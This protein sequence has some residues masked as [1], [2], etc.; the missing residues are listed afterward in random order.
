MIVVVNALLSTCDCN[1]RFSDP[2]DSILDVR[3]GAMSNDT[4]REKLIATVGTHTDGRFTNRPMWVPTLTQEVNYWYKKPSIRPLNCSNSRGE[5]SVVL[6]SFF[7]TIHDKPIRGSFTFMEIGAYDGMKESNTFFFEKCL[8]WTGVLAEAH[9]RTFQRLLKSPRT[10][11]KRHV[12]VCETP[13]LVT[14]SR[15]DGTPAH[16]VTADTR[17]GKL[18]DCLPMSRIV[19]SYNR[20]DFLSLDVEGHEPQAIRSLGTQT[21]FGDCGGGNGW[22]AAK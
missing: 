20:I 16:I 11:E 21:S 3:Y 22:C 6:R 15:H 5:D 8:N 10:V 14:I 1:V 18:V 2:T 7:S 13:Q 4:F 9:P 17:Q 19:E 12:A